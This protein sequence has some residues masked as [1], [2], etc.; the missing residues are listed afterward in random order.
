M[1]EESSRPPIST[2]V[3]RFW[4]ERSAAGPRWRGQIKHVES[5]ETATFLD[6]KQML[7]FFR[8]IG[9]KLPRGYDGA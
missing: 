3:I 6:W 2:F 1:T 9:I 7:D 8:R 4:R 5:G